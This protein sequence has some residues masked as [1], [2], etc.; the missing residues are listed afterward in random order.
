MART[1]DLSLNVALTNSIIASP[2]TFGARSNGKISE[3]TRKTIS[4]VG[5]CL[6]PDVGSIHGSPPADIAMR[7]ILMFLALGF[8]LLAVR[9]DYLHT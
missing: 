4:S 8:A 7:A 1:A 3:L 9:T 5:R 2:D 6:C